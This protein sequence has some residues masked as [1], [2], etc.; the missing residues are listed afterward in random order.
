MRPL[1][2]TQKDVLRS[3]RNHRG[4]WYEGCGWLWNTISGTTKIMES[5][6]K[7]GLVS[8]SDHVWESGKRTPRYDLTE[9]GRKA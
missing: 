5:L 1:G 3:L 8:K 7:R 9:D 4:F 6:Y 2:E